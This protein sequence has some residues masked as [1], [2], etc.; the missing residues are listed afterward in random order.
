MSDEPSQDVPWTVHCDGSAAPNPGR[1]GLG[2]LI[3]SP[4]GTQHAL[5]QVADGRG[6]NNEAEVRALML[7]LG[8]LQSLGASGVQ[9][10]CD[11]SIVVDQLTRSDAPSL[12]RLA[13]LFDEARSLLGV[14]KR[15][16]IVWVPRHRNR[17][18]DA[19]ARA[20]L[21]LPAKA[22]AKIPKGRRRHAR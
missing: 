22:A 6:C 14:F 18:A 20:A 4:D 21:G 7:A 3:V 11:N 8:F 17:D 2:A 10:H 16:Q 13:P 19:L 9:V 5:S 15:V 1:M 12:V